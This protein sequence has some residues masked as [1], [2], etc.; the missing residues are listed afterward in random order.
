MKTMILII[1]YDKQLGNIQEFFYAD[2]LFHAKNFVAEDSQTYATLHTY[3]VHDDEAAEADK[4]ET[5]HPYL[6][7]DTERFRYR[8]VKDCPKVFV[9]Y[10]ESKS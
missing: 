10:D 9:E 6:E 4:F 7:Y 2:S 5:T 1:R 3:A 8:I